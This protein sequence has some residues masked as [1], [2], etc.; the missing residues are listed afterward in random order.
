MVN[1]TGD[2][3]ALNPSSGACDTG[4][5]ATDGSGNTVPECTLR[6]A[7]QVMDLSSAATQSLSFNIPGGGIPVLTPSS[8][9]PAI[10]VP[11]TI[12]GTT[13]PGGWVTIN[14][15]GVGTGTSGVFP[16]QAPNVTVS[17]LSVISTPRGAFVISGAGSDTVSGDLLG[18]T[19]A[20]VLGLDQ[21]GLRSAH[22]R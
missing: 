3:P 6:A 8:P 1:S 15:S 7:I 20:G 17:G 13:E 9:Y 21:L 10:T 4:Q 14:G 19:P 2:L 18:V 16:I 11:M 22:R 5:T 12:D